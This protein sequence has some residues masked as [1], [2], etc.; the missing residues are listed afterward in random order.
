MSTA[1][2]RSFS[3]SSGRA[4]PGAYQ[5]KKMKSI[6]KR[7]A[8]QVA[9]GSNDKTIAESLGVTTQMVAYTRKSRIVQEYL[10]LLEEDIRDDAIDV[11][12]EIQELSPFAIRTIETTMLDP[13][14][15]RKL[16]TELAKD[17]LDRAGHSPVHRSEGIV[18]HMTRN[19][20]EEIKQRARSSGVVGRARALP[21]RDAAEAE[22]G[23]AERAMTA[24]PSAKAAGEAE[25]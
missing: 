10:G 25:E 14:T 15:D 20:I 3:P 6:H 5:L 16:R 18:A 9:V 7:I 21:P 11:A 24:V 13:L 8:E 22:R 4:A 17:I 19:D 2:S 1:L 23:A 12:R